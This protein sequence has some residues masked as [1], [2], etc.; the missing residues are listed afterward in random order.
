MR[1]WGGE[2]Q[3]SKGLFYVGCSI[4]AQFIGKPSYLE[5]N[6]GSMQKPIGGLSA[7]AVFATNSMLKNATNL[8]AA[9]IKREGVQ[10]PST[11][12]HQLAKNPLHNPEKP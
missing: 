6:S 7:L 1:G 3:E 4:Y 8:F 11:T 12:V 9:Y 2:S 10:F 5:P